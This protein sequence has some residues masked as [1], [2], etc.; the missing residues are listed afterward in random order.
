MGVWVGMGVGGARFRVPSYRFIRSGHKTNGKQCT[1]GKLFRTFRSPCHYR[2]RVHSET[3]SEFFR[4]D[5][6]MG[7]RR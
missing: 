2:F 4:P 5:F 6:G 1:V 7:L 3:G